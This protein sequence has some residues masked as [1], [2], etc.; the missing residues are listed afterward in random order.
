MDSEKF[1]KEI[2]NLKHQQ[3]QMEKE[4]K[5]LADEYI[6]IK[7]NYMAL[8]DERDAEVSRQR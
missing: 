5:A 8:V 6:N 4:R 2:E 1:R 3:E 7:T